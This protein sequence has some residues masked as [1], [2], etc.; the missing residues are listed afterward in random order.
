MKRKDCLPVLNETIIKTDKKIYLELLRVIACFFV[1]VN[2]TANGITCVFFEGPNYF[3]AS[4]ML[5]MSRIAVPIFLMISGAVLIP[6]EESIE[7][8]IK[9]LVHMMLVFIGASLIYYLKYIGEMNGSFSVRDFFYIIYTG[10]VTNAFW[11]MYLYFALLIML[12]ILRIIAKGI[13]NN[14]LYKIYFVIWVIFFSIIPALCK[15]FEIVEYT[16]DFNLSLLSG[17]VVY[18]IAGYIIDSHLNRKNIRKIYSLIGAFSFIVGGVLD[19]II[20]YYMSKNNIGCYLFDNINYF[21]V[22]IPAF[23]A[24]FF[25][26]SIFLNLSTSE[27]DK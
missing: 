13:V 27:P 19:G 20:W 9:R 22:A 10:N 26:L 24:L 23:F 14:N 11:Y 5:C 8:Q 4:M 18:F 2:H 6:K 17:Y 15:Q 21:M 16:S 3:F 1:I 25:I 12:P 7:A